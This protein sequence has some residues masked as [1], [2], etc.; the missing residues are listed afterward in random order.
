MSFIIGGY[1]GVAL[2]ILLCLVAV[3][4]TIIDTTTTPKINV[5]FM[6]IIIILVSIFITPIYMWYRNYIFKN[7]NKGDI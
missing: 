2:M 7:K 4:I 1:V 3:Y 6:S 5:F